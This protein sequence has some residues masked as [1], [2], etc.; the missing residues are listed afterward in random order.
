MTLAVYNI[1][2]LP[3]KGT[4]DLTTPL[5]DYI[6]IL[7]SS[8]RIVDAIRTGPIEHTANLETEL[9]STRFHLASMIVLAETHLRRSAT[10]FSDPAVS[11]VG[12]QDALK[13]YLSAL[14]RAKAAWNAW[15]DRTPLSFGIGL[16]GDGTGVPTTAEVKE[17]EQQAM[18][19][20]QASRPKS[21]P[22]S[23]LYL[24][25]GL[26]I[27]AIISMLRS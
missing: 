23:L 19:V 6:A 4:R 2:L 27:V 12:I 18:E 20:V 3:Q 14:L 25:G 5:R 10:N 17:M 24:G 26:A 11:V 9:D 15:I 16:G 13:R 1:G 22:E 21:I 7:K 8:L